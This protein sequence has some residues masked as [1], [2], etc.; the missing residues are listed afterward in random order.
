VA[1]IS[2]KPLA[3]LILLAAILFHTLPVFAGESEYSGKA[4]SLDLQDASIHSA[5]RI[6]A[7]VSNLNVVVHPEVHGKVNLKLKDVPWDQVLDVILKTHG[8]YQVR[9]GNV[10]IIVPYDKVPQLF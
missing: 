1:H 8:L 2:E 5:F 4:I 6:I 3:A 10:L 7:E 9:E